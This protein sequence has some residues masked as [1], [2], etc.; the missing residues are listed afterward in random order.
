MLIGASAGTN[1][2]Q[3]CVALTRLVVPASR[4]DEYA[5]A[6]V[7]GYQSLKIGDPMEAD[8]VLGPPRDRA[9]A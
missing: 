6:L 4:Y 7:A 1:S 5:E 2:G 8:T 3:S 9:P